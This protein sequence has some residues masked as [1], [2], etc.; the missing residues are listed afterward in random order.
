M[1]FDRLVAQT[2]E[3]AS[4]MSGCYNRLQAIIKKVGKH[5]VYVHCKAHTLNVVLA[6]SANVFVK[7]II[8]FNNLETLNVLFSKTQKIHALFGAVQMEENLKVLSRKKL[9]TA[10]ERRITLSTGKLLL[11][12]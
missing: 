6:D 9:N 5:V 3:G 8:F 7:V 12:L 1:S 2:Y 4:N 11:K 10:A